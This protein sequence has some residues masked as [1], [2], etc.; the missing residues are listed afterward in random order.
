MK[1]TMNKNQYTNLINSLKDYVLYLEYNEDIVRKKLK[2]LC[3]DLNIKKLIETKSDIGVFCKTKKN[4]SDVQFEDLILEQNFD[5]YWG[6]LDVFFKDKFFIVNTNLTY[7]QICLLKTNTGFLLE[8]LVRNKNRL[9]KLICDFRFPND[10]EVIELC[11]NMNS[12]LNR[13][14]FD[15]EVFKK[16]LEEF[17]LDN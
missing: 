1:V 12:R 8:N 2:K 9:D 11:D 13:A 17:L 7:T 6:S 4:Y 14:V 5:N 3:Q 16:K 10:F 15:F